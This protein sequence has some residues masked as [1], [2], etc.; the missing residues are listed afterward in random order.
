MTE[1]ETEIQ[2]PRD[3]SESQAKKNACVC[4][5]HT[6]KTPSRLQQHFCGCMIISL[7]SLQAPS[8]IFVFLKPRSMVIVILVVVVVVAAAVGVVGGR[9]GGR[10]AS[11][12]LRM[13]VRGMVCCFVGLLAA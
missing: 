5:L 11:L 4:H 8:R 13:G 1:M 12:R 7:L 9:G 3:W 2:A 6:A 10:S